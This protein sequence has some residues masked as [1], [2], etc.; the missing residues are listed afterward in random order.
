[1]RLGI[2]LCDDVRPELQEKH[3]NYPAMFSE[4]FHQVSSDIELHF[5]RVIDGQYP[6]SLD[7]CDAYVSSGSKYSVYDDIRWIR[8]FE[9]FIHQLFQQHV[10]FVGI[11][12][13]HQMIARALG[14]EVCRTDKGWGLGVAEVELQLDEVSKHSWLTPAEKRYSLL[15]SHQDQVIEPPE[16]T[17]VLAGSAFCPYAMIQVGSHFL[18][19]QGHPE[20]TPEYS[21]DLI[22][23]RR[24]SY[25]PQVSEHALLSLSQPTDYIGVTQWMINFIK[26]R[27]L[28]FSR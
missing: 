1:M 28:N 6:E 18:G 26:L 12:F 25:P 3:G 21:H 13:G 14:G 20:F 11:C 4:L 5:Y 27:H 17:R 8:T 2:L 22:K 7:E 19:I 23:L 10:P 24:D 16:Q 9:A 15:V